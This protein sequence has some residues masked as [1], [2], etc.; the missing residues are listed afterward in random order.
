MYG[1]L[2]TGSLFIPSQSPTRMAPVPGTHFSTQFY[3]VT[4]NPSILRSINKTQSHHSINQIYY[5][6]IGEVVCASEKHQ[7]P[8]HLWL[9]WSKSSLEVN[10]WSGNPAKAHARTW[11]TNSNRYSVF[12]WT[13]SSGGPIIEWCSF[14]QEPSPHFK[15][16]KIWPVN[17]LVKKR[18]VLIGLRKF[19][20]E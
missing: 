19:V 17:R 10:Q 16:P 13:A 9:S 1:C 6:K 7:S 18:S 15:T 11:T 3:K 12:Y 8:P 5:E 20:L 2:V 14:L 4:A